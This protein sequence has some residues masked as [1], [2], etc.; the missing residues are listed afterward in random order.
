MKNLGLLLLRLVLGTLM[1]GHGAQKLFGW[2]KGPGL[3]GTQG[4]VESLGMAPGTAWGTMAAAGEFSGGVLTATGFLS[5]LGPLN[6]ASSMIVATRRVHWKTP[7]WVSEGGAELAVTNLAAALA[8]SF[9]GPGRFSLDSMFGIKLP[10]TVVALIY[11]A[12]GGVTYAALQKPEL[13]QT[14]MDGAS[15]LMPSSM[16]SQSVSDA[17]SNSSSDIVVET[18]PKTDVTLETVTNI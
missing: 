5:P 17:S 1:A 2:F 4:F 12:L 9:A 16:G 8:L 13:A 6:I 7:V 3:K 10:R 14:V 18:I 15:G 11:L